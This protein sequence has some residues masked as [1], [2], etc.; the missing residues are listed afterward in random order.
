MVHAAKPSR[1]VENAALFLEE[2]HMLYS[3]FAARRFGTS[4][5]YSQLALQR[6]NHIFDQLSLHT[7]NQPHRFT[8]PE[9]S[10]VKM[11]P[12]LRKF[13]PTLEADFAATEA[14]AL[15]RVSHWHSFS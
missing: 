13:W 6:L 10:L 14:A 8:K 4:A 12:E 15:A 1:T 9:L 5:A 2:Y 3:L 11:A 7:K